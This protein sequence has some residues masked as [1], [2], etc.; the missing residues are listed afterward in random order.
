MDLLHAGDARVDVDGAYGQRVVALLVSG[1]HG[2]GVTQVIHHALDDALE[3][4]LL[5]VQAALHVED[6]ALDAFGLHAP[7]LAQ[8]GR[9]YL[10]AN[11]AQQVD[12][13]FQ[14]QAALEKVKRE[15]G[16]DWE[17]E[18]YWLADEALPELEKAGLPARYMQVS[19]CAG[20]FVICIDI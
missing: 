15:A 8:D 6:Q 1:H 7:P 11:C 12:I 3:D 18:F 4:G 2:A 14:D 16:S 17:E 10:A 20:I 9:G 13:A 5:V 19:S